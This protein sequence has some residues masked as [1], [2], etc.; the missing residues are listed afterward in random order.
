MPAYSLQARWLLP[1]D[2]PPIA[3]G[4]VTIDEG[5]IIALEKSHDGAASLED[6]GDVVLLPGLV[7][8]HTHLEFNDLQ[9]PLGTAGMSLPE[10]IG[11]VIAERKRTQR[12]TGA[13][14]A[15]GMRECLAEGVTCVGEI[16]TAPAEMYP[17]TTE[18]PRLSLFREAI[19]F[20]A[21]RSDSVLDDVR[22]RVEQPTTC[23]LTVSGLSPHAPYTV[24]PSLVERLVKLACE[25]NLPIAMHLAE[26]Q[27]ELCLLAQGDGPFRELLEERSMWDPTAIP[28]GTTPLDYLKVLSR[29]PRSLV[30]HGNYLNEAEINYVSQH[31]KQMSVVYCPRTHAYFLHSRYPLRKMLSAGVRIAVGTDSR[32]SNPDLGVLGELRHIAETF[33]EI[34]PEKILRMG[35]LAGAEALGCETGSGSIAAGKWADL[36][37]VPCNSTTENPVEALLRDS[38][39]PLRTWL[40]G[41]EVTGSYTS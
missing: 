5:R 11:L 29:A 18:V 3:G 41:Q 25:E 27:E 40:G 4:V 17:A 34:E 20:S 16:S 13:A 23:Q 38:Q 21:A 22:Q 1:V 2:R 24:H 28:A 15:Q 33:S 14:I 26:S 30:V 19:G 35:T 37:A 32:A 39:P 6:L 12:D 36:T 7:N 10:W 31:R 9:R 8:A